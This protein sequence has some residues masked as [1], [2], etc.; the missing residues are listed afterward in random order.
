MSS[1]LLSEKKRKQSSIGNFLSQ[2]R[3]LPAVQLKSSGG[4]IQCPW[5]PAGTKLFTAQGFPSHEHTH[6][7]ANDPNNNNN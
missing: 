2:R 1:Q 5:C 6:K 7:E 3:S 4:H